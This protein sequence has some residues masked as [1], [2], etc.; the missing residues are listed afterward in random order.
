MGGRSDGPRRTT[1]RAAAESWRQVG[2][3]SPARQASKHVALSLS[4]PAAPSAPPPQVEGSNDAACESGEGAVARPLP[5]SSR[6][7]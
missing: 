5:A 2:Q 4:E 1:E 6:R 3:L 7:S